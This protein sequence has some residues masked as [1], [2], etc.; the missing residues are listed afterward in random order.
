MLCAD[1]GLRYTSYYVYILTIVYDIFFPPSFVTLLSPSS[2]PSP[3]LPSPPSSSPPLPSPPSSSLLL[4]SP[5]SS[6]T[7]NRLTTIKVAVNQQPTN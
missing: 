4:P 2:Y 5:P 6:F 1:M 3:L 7:I